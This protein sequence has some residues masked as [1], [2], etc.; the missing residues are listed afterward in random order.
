MWEPVTK[1]IGQYPGYT[2]ALTLA[3]VTATLVIGG[4]RA[5]YSAFLEA[6]KD[7]L[8]KLAAYCEEVSDTVAQ[9]VAS[10]EY[11][12][13]HINKFWAYYYGKLI[14]VEDENLENKMV[15]LGTVL[16]KTTEQS[17]RDR[18]KEIANAV[19]EVSGACRDLLKKSWKLAIV[20][21][22]DLQ[23]KSQNE[24]SPS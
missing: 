10:D 4:Y 9:I 7:Y 20:P 18:R 16:E 3:Y 19:L 17:F 5:F 14:L 22:R 12:K 11:P 23:R 6:K 15:D 13:Q 24:N 2:L 8:A 21:W 1:L